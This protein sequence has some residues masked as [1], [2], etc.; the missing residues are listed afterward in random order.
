[1]R[2]YVYMSASSS[3]KLFP[4]LPPDRMSEIATGPAVAV[5]TERPSLP[6]V[7]SVG[8]SKP[9]SADPVKKVG[10]IDIGDSFG[11]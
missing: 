6:P 5:G 1:M 8:A 7:G 2:A 4:P 11:G 3:A 9:V 10:G